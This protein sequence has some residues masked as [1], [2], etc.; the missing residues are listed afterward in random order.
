MVPSQFCLMNPALLDPNNHVPEVSPDD[1][2]GDAEG[3]IAETT[4]GAAH[5]LPPRRSV[6]DRSPAAAVESGQTGLRIDSNPTRGPSTDSPQRLEV[7]EISGRVVRLNPLAAAPPKVPRQ[8][9][10]HERPAGAPGGQKPA[11]ESLQWGLAR[12][13]PTHWI[14]GAGVAVAIV[15]VLGIMALPAIN[16]PN[17]PRPVAVAKPFVDEKIEG[18]EAMNLLLAKQPEA[19]RI[20]RAYATA[21]GVDDIVPLVR[22]GDLLK[23]TL[24]SNWRPQEISKAWEPATDTRWTVIELAGRPCGLLQGTFPDHSKFF[25]YFINDG[26]QLRLDWKATTGFGTASFGQLEKNSGDPS[27]IRGELSS[28]D[29]YNGILPEADY[30]CYRLISP[31]REIAIWCYARRD[32][33]ADQ[34]IAPLVHQNDLGGEFQSSR[35]I[36]LRLTSGPNGAMPNQW[37]I[38]ELLHLDWVTP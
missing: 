27:E 8:I 16:A 24:L 26:S 13:R 9:T 11:D 19:Q 23:A 15:V 12:R 1:G 29:Y 30:H 5:V 7:Q 25:A 31:D 10:F 20:F 22:D 6:V 35:K 38:E 36:T 3:V 37:L 4:A 2:W 21:S 28:A 32:E 17:A 34:A 14:L 18:M 33:A